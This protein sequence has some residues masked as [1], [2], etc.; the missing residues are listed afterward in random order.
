MV[1]EI[2]LSI[3][4]LISGTKKRNLQETWHLTLKLA[5]LPGNF[6]VNIL[7][8]FYS[9][10]TAGVIFLCPEFQNLKLPQ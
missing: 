8:P 1:F 2:R 3:Y 10:G 4:G 5:G 9:I 6:T 7:D